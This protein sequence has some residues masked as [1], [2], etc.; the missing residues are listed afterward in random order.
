MSS[1]QSTIQCKL[2]PKQAS[3]GTSVDWLAC[4]RL[5]VLGFSSRFLKQISMLNTEGQ[6]PR[7][8]LDVMHPD[9]ATDVQTKQDNRLRNGSREVRP[10]ELEIKDDVYLRN[11]PTGSTWIQGVVIGKRGPRSYLVELPDGRVFRRHIDNLR[12]RVT[13]SGSEE[14][15]EDDWLTGNMELPGPRRI[16]WKIQ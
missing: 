11:L 7:T 3:Y 5:L 1:M 6:R 13:S 10:S 2:K 15:E 14:R 16:Q 8:H 9:L 4:C 12:S